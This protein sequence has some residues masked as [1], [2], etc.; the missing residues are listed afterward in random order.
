M[1]KKLLSNLPF[2]P[3]LIGQVS[4]YAKRLH[5]E[6][7]IRRVGVFLVIASLGIQLFAVIAPAEP[8]LASSNSDIVTG[9]FQSQAEAVQRCRAGGDFTNIMS[10]FGVSC[11]AL[12]A[13]SG[14]YVRRMNYNEY[15][16]QL[17]SIGRAPNG[18]VADIPINIGGTVF[19]M[20]SLP[21]AWGQNCINDNRGC[22]AIVGTRND[23]T[24]FMVLMACGN[25]VIVGPPVQEQPP[26]VVSCHSLNMSVPPSSRVAINTKIKLTGQASGANLPPG[27][28]I[29]MYY[30]YVEVNQPQQ[31]LGAAS[32]RGVPYSGNLATDGTPREFTM[33]KAGHF[34]FR[35]V[36]KYEGSSK[37]A[38]GSLACLK[39]VYVETQ[40]KPEKEY[41][42][43]NLIGSFTSGQRVVTG[44][45][46]N[47]RGV[48]SGR[49]LGQGDLV[50]MYY[51]YIDSSGKVLGRAEARGAS[52]KDNVAEDTTPRSFKLDK[53]GTYKFRLNVK[54]DSS[55]KTA[56]GSQTGNCVKEIIVQPPCEQ[57]RNNNDLECLIL[58]KTAENKT[59]GIK[60]AHNTVANPGDVVIYGLAVKNT[61]KDTTIKGY[62]VQENIL[63]IL[64]YADVTDYHGGTNKE[65]IVTWPA[66]DI[67]ANETINKQIT[68]RIKNP[69][70]QTPVAASN[71]S[72]FDMKL[73]NHFGN[74]VEIKLPPST[75]KTTEQIV[76]T[77]PNTGPG[78]T[79][80]VGFVVV[81]IVS[82]FFARSRLMAKEL[83]LVR[84]DYAVSGG[85]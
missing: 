5:K 51:D 21:G 41:A 3:S 72:S 17:Y 37:T 60:D 35:L 42:C 8:S 79:L 58:S 49:N 40:P 33:T 56:T 9:G 32:A 34:V 52:F 10:R 19:L 44:T 48:A 18:R 63:D 83:E 22:Q 74:T 28:L 73:T 67:K 38:V 84:N 45:T 43:S 64:E 16:G 66:Q 14:A 11:D 54:Y 25:I 12:D 62:Q 36:V 85:M 78:E 75:P 2:N 6:T 47:V 27:E 57:S 68:V 1:F 30:D 80:A 55:T 81:V 65:G 46:V 31:V 23:G 26:K 39:D 69:L 50:D 77:L 70:P 61:S 15:G 71:P 24:P 82:Y 13:R 59:Q 20:R 76:T 4:F 7:A 53:A 29:D